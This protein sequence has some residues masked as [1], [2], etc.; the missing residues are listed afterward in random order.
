MVDEVQE[1]KA[2]IE[3]LERM[4]SQHLGP[5]RGSTTIQIPH[6]GV[7][8]LDEDDLIP[9]SYLTAPTMGLQKEV[10]IPPRSTSA[11][12]YTGFGNHFAVLTNSTTPR[13]GNFEFKIPSDFASLDECHIDIIPDAT[14]TIQYDLYIQKALT[15]QQYNAT[16]YSSLNQTKS[17]TAN[18]IT[19]ID[20]TSLMNQFIAADQHVGVKFGADLDSIYLLG[21]HFVYTSTTLIY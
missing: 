2:R 9:S 15:D 12:F 13:I 7:P 10:Y 5:Q 21:M 6:A 18:L 16:D 4:M 19:E 1:L 8:L 3:S 11:T 14:E 17:V 20:I